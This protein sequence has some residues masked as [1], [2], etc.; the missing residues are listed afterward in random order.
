MATSAGSLRNG[1]ARAGTPARAGLWPAGWTAALRR[2]ARRAAGVMLILLAAAILVALLGYDGR[3]PSLDTASGR[4]PQNL[5]GL[6]GAYAADLLL[7]LLGAAA[8]APLVLPAVAGLR[9]AAGG[10][11]PRW[12][13]LAVLTAAG[14]VL[15]A[16]A[17]GGLVATISPYPAGW[18]GMT[19]LLAATL[20]AGLPAQRDPAG[21]AD[22]PARSA[23]RHQ[24][25]ARRPT[26][27]LDLRQ[28]S[29][30]LP[31]QPADDRRDEQA[32]AE[33]RAGPPDRRQRRDIVAEQQQDQ[34]GDARQNRA[35]TPPCR[36]EHTL[37]GPIC[38]RERRRGYGH[39]HALRQRCGAGAP[40]H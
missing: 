31:H 3:D 5:L 7:A 11:M 9:L 12:R 28:T 4:T 33:G 24:H 26:D 6:P 16:A 19:G 22:Q 13:R 8:F 37:A 35:I 10:T 25:Q 27:R 23:D 21:I 2:A 18:G 38:A 17:I 36:S 39:G 29:A 1:S 34:H 32:M 14:T 30:T 15:L 20:L 40:L